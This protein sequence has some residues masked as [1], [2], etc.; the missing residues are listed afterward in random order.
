LDL[1]A[2]ATHCLHNQ[3]DLLS[4]DRFLFVKT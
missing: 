4:V 3:N 2:S 1:L